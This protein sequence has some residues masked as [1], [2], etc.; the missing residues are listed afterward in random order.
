MRRDIDLTAWA[1]GALATVQ[2]GAL[3]YG[4]I[5]FPTT[6]LAIKLGGLL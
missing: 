4:W 1:V 6:K 3:V 5:W 2:I